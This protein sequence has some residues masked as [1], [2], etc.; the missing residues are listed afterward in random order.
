[1]KK[2]SDG[3]SRLRADRG[4]ELEGGGGCYLINLIRSFTAEKGSQDVREELVQGSPLV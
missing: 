1:M 4:S 2:Q 3:R